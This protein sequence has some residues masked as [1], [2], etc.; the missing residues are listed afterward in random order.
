MKPLIEKMGMKRGCGGG[1]AGKPGVSGHGSVQEEKRRRL[2]LIG[3]PPYR[4]G[5]ARVTFDILLDYL[6]RFPPLAM[7]VFDLPV[8]H[9][10]YDHGGLP[11]PLSHRRTLMG[12]LRALMRTPRVD[13]VVLVGSSDVCFS[14]GVAFVLCAKL[15]RKSCVARMTGGR[16]VFL[17]KRLP[18]PI[19][20]LCFFLFRA[21]DVFSV[22]TEV[23]RNDLPERLRAKTV[24]VRGFRPR[25]P[26]LPPIRR[27]RGRTNFAFVGRT[28]STESGSET[29]EK[30]LDVLLDSGLH[31]GRL[32]PQGETT[33]KGLDVLLDAFDR[34]RNA[35]SSPRSMEV[36][37]YGRIPD[38]L[39][40]RARRTPGVFAHG[41]LPN[42]RLRAAL[43][44]HDVLAF[45]SRA[46]SEGHPGAIVEAFVAGL[47]VIA[48][49]LSGPSEIVKD[50]VNGLI[51]RTGDP[52]AFAAAMTKLAADRELLCRL[53]D[54]ARASASEF[55]QERVL[56][57]LSEA[58]GLLPGDAR[59]A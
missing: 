45:P 38:S 28:A 59:P 31:R 41:Y 15:F 26:V 57:E 19:R 49:D 1:L 30:G 16:A 54:G 3:P 37:I 21:I 58:L 2:L 44:Q 4:D 18:A 8:H 43:Q 56:P 9:P 20:A 50:G 35:R 33:E 39:V 32:R 5:G 36:H 7:E 12:T 46:W 53:T 42:D 11:G 14:Y 34:A 47:P 52:E 22:E 13:T 25:G 10:F 40:E 29:T 23:A 48:S 55:D 24:V 6:G 27:D 51:V 17:S